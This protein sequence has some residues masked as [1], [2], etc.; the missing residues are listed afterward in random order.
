MNRPVRN[1]KLLGSELVIK[2]QDKFFDVI[3]AVWT[4]HDARGAF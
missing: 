2:S 4:A 1:A 3:Y